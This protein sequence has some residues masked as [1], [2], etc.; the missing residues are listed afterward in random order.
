MTSHHFSIREAKLVPPRVA[1]P[2]IA[3]PQLTR[4]L[5]DGARLPLA[6]LTAEAGYG[7]TSLLLA[8]LPEIPGPV[9]WL[10]L[11]ETD[12]DPTLFAAALI[13][14]LQRVAAGVGGAALD[15]LT[16]SPGGASLRAA[17]GRTLEEL[18][19]EIALV[20]DDF[21][22]LD[23]TPESLALVDHLL[24]R[25]PPHVHL[26]IASRT[27]P[28]LRS[29]SSLAVRGA[30]RVLTRGDLA[31][32]PKEVAAFLLERH[33]VPVDEGLATHLAHRTEGWPAALQL[34]AMVH[35]GRGSL[36]LEGTPR[37]IFDYLK[38]PPT[39][40]RPTGRPSSS[41]PAR[42]PSSRPDRSA[43]RAT[44]RPAA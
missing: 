15:L 30:V 14:S 25:L 22:V 8:S 17:I 34:A 43:G 6:V 11:D 7:K 44:C 26:V 20:V 23:Q 36:G 31:F 24:T 3:R 42:P 33:G 21:H 18:P 5:R 39:S 32:T 2:L 16:A 27:Q 29:L 19:G 37:E 28:A 38:G 35:R 9:A 1:G 13:L 12:S 41:T 10:T 40:R 4:M